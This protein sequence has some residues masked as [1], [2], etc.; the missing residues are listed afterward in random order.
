[1]KRNKWLC[2]L[3]G[4]SL[5]EQNSQLLLLAVLTRV[6]EHFS[7]LLLHTHA[8]CA[9]AHAMVASALVLSAQPLRLLLH[10]SQMNGAL[11]LRR[12][13]GTSS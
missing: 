4:L 1:M 3:Y 10:A 12:L 5:G 2:T 11:C 13:T 7:Q 6:L 9:G 8:P